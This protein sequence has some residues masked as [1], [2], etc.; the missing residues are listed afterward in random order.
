MGFC[1]AP[2]DYVSPTGNK[3]ELD[4][5]S[6]ADLVACMEIA[7]YSLARSGENAAANIMF[8]AVAEL[9]KTKTN[10]QN[11]AIARGPAQHAGRA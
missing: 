3:R 11:R 2:S 9:E 4:L 6:L 5:E 1:P 10:R 7:A 8:C